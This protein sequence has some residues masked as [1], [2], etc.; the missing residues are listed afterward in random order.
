MSPPVP[1]PPSQWDFGSAPWPED[2]DCV[3]AGA[4][5]EPA[6]IVEAYRNG[7]F[8]MPHGGELLWWS[9]VERGVLRPGDLHVSRSL[10]RSMRRFRLTIDE[11]FVAVIDGCADPRRP[12]GWIDGRIRA[13]YEQLHAWGWAHSVEVWDD[14]GALVGGLY[15]LAI[16]RLFAGESMFHRATDASKAALAGLV[17]FLQ[18]QAETDYLI[19]TQWQTPHLASLGVST[20]SR[21]EYRRR[22][23]DLVDA[24]AW[25]WPSS[26]TG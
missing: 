8:P 17:D 18:S 1:L 9:P 15:G 16:G 19:D 12:G 20:M 7:L 2:D 5:L 25:T 3:A 24:P 26:T 22:I 10:R 14:D 4:D 23:V 6:T 11:D 21:A 13:A